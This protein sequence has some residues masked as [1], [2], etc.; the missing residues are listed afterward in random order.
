MRAHLAGY[1]VGRGAKVADGAAKCF[2][3][4]AIKASPGQVS[5]FVVVSQRN[6]EVVPELA[7]IDHGIGR[8]LHGH[9]SRSA[10]GVCRNVTLSRPSVASPSRHASPYTTR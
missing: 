10:Y 8:N 9:P 4:A 7:I 2:G 6:Q 5:A 1:R 3:S